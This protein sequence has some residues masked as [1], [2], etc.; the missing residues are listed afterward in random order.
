MKIK[1][2]HRHSK[3][4]VVICLNAPLNPTYSFPWQLSTYSHAQ[5]ACPFT[6]ITLH[7]QSH[8]YSPKQ[9]YVHNNTNTHPFNYFCSRQI[10]TTIVQYNA[11]Q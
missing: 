3:L 5:L 10:G 9:N 4:P 6:F 7:I 2:G 1:N 11:I 8:N